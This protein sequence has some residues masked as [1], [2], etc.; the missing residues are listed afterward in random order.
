MDPYQKLSS[1]EYV[2]WFKSVPCPAVVDLTMEIQSVVNTTITDKFL[3]TIDEQRSDFLSRLQCRLFL[4]PSGTAL[5]C[6]LIEPPATLVFGKLLYGGITRYRLLGTTLSSSSSSTSKQQ[7]R[8]VGVR[9]DVQPTLDDIV[10]TWIMYGGSDRMYESVD[11][12][13][14]A[15]LEVILYPRGQG[16]NHQQFTSTASFND[17]TIMQLVGIT[18]KPQFMFH[19]LPVTSTTSQAIST[20]PVVTM[21]PSGKRRNDAFRDGIRSN[22]GGLQSQIDTIVRRVL[23][24]RVIR[25]VTEY[26]N[27]N[28][29]NNFTSTTVSSDT[30][31]TA[32]LEAEELQLLGLT[33]VRG[34]LLYGPPGCGTY[35]CRFCYQFSSFFY[36]VGSLTLSSYAHWH[37]NSYF[38]IV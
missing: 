2:R 11:M 9:T 13:P 15:L 6:P 25:P 32:S 26:D 22:I 31:S 16:K 12:G 14:A 35:P 36:R 30:F 27:D 29:N 24:G 20:T 10:P 33:P 18:W 7:Q 28:I 37:Q 4:L 21:L 17:K 3:Q 34:L 1:M 38:T 19:T 5:P 8:R 23:D